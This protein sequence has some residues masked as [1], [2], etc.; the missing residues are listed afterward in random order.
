MMIISYQKITEPDQ[1][2]D[3]A[4]DT[5]FRLKAQMMFFHQDP[6]SSVIYSIFFGSENSLVHKTF[7]VLR[8]KVFLTSK[9]TSG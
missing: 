1:E 7:T 6:D 5:I 9:S 4:F 2:S 3:Q 8:L